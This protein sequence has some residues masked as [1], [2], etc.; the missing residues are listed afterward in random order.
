MRVDGGAAKN[1]LL[2]SE[3]ARLSALTIE[4]PTDL[5]TT[6]RGAAM[7][8]AVGAG[9]FAGKDDAAAMSPLERTFEPAGEDREDAR[10]GW[11]RAVERSR[12]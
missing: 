9:L 8:A 4:R 5:E 2:M 10:A 7:L 12:Q 6:A 3:Q 11:K 1:D